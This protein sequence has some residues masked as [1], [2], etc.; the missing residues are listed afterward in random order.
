MTFPPPEGQPRYGEFAPSHPAVPMATWDA[1]PPP[2]APPKRRRLLPVLLGVGISFAV[3]I[4]G[5]TTAY[6]QR[7]N[8]R[9][10]ITVWN[11]EPTA[12]ITGYIERSKMS[13]RGE[14]LFKASEPIVASPTEF[15]ETCGSLEEGT[16]VLGC[17]IP[18]SR[19]IFLFD[20]TDDR[21][22]GVEEVVASHEMLHAVWDRMS[23]SDR[24]RIGELLEK[25]AAGLADDEAFTERMAVY[26]R[27]EPGERLNELH[28]ILGTEIGDLGPDL[29]EHYAEYFV[30]RA[31]VVELHV[32]SNAVLK[33]IEQRTTALVAE[34]DK[35]YDEVEADNDRYTSGYDKLDKDVAAFN[36]KNNA[37]GFSSQAEF[38]AERNALIARQKKLDKLYKSIVK[39]DAIYKEKS[40]ELEELNAQAASLNKELNIVERESEF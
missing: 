9:D 13:D 33:D 20:V 15:N 1:P 24:A 29:D 34:L 36:A 35:L 38:D 32:T 30:D 18:A 12:I 16:G 22:D 17:Y 28:S 21:L 8:V 27:A 37:Y 4:A 25:A 7:D 3:I 31:A 2:P 6:V 10:L 5:A 11:Y 19:Q 23:E 14:F 26:A 40:A 39:R